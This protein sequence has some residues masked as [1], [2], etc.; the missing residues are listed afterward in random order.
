[1]ITFA[2]NTQDAEQIVQHPD[3]YPHVGDDGSPPAEQF[4]IPDSWYCVVGYSDGQPAGCWLMHHTNS[5]TLEVH[6]QVLKEYRTH[7]E[8]ICR[9]FIAWAWDNTPAQK[10]VA[11]IPTLYPNVKAF[12]ETMGFRVEGINASSIQ[13][14]GQLYD[15]YYMGLTKWQH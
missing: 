10:L 3:I 8:E 12:A 13:K 6:I 5:T 11:Q 4:T 15:Q 14:D 9:G 7:S 1:M 2:V